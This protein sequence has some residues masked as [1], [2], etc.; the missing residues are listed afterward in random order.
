MIYWI[1]DDINTL[2][3][4]VDEFKD[5]GI[6][7][8][9]FKTVDE[10]YEEAKK[11]KNIDAFIIDVML[12][13]GDMY[14]SKETAA[15]TVTGINL[16]KSLREVQEFSKTPIFVFTGVINE[17]A[18]HYAEKLGATILKNKKSIWPDELVGSIK[19]VLGTT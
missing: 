7:I 18:E 6:E 3:A 16:I 17:T 2:T 8:R 19:K 12:P 10:L 15:G 4:F 11:N 9:L 1:D 13:Y 14:S 5:A